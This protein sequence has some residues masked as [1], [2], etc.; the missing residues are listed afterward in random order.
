MSGGSGESMKIEDILSGGT[1][2]KNPRFS[3]GK[4]VQGISLAPA[5]LKES[6][7]MAGVGAIHIS[8]IKPTLARLERDLGVDLQNNVLGSVGKKEWS[9]DIDVAMNIPDDEIQEFIKRVAKSGIV[10]EAKKGPLVVISRV[11]IQDYNPDLETDKNRTGFVQ[12]DF[13]IDEDTGWLKT[14]YHSPSDTESAYKGAHRN[15]V[16]GAL[17]QYVDRIESKEKTDDGRPMSIER[18][19]FSSKK[20]LVRIRRTPKPKA[21]GQGYTQA[22]DNEIIGGPW[23]TG[24]EIAK[25][26]KLGNNSNLNSFESVFTAIEK[27]LGPETAKRVA[28]DVSHDK[29]IQK[30]GVPDEIGKYL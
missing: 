25:K 16:I 22:F 17:S 19:M 30:L 23:K 18:Y 27:N 26:L 12:V 24:D 29:A 13:M 28:V 14:F 10:D 1:K 6:G 4:R 5:R 20:G 7:G 3:R 2:R 21:N 15:I 11:K 9:G 8:E